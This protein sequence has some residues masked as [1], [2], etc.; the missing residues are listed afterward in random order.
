MDSVQVN[1]SDETRNCE[2]VKDTVLST[3]FNND[4]IDEKQYEEYNNKWG[5]ILIKTSWY[6]RIFK[7]KKDPKN[8]EY[9]FVKLEN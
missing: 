4:V 3:L 1:L 5:L 9:R 7:D 6:T 2:T 8:W